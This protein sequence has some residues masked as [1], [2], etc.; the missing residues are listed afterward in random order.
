MDKDNVVSIP[1][2]DLMTPKQVAEHFKVPVGRVYS[3]L[4]DGRLKG[5]KTGWGILLPKPNLPAV[6]PGRK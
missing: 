3:A 5:I 1:V 2:S 6:W 4:R